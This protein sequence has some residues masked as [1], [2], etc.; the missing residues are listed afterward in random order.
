MNLRVIVLGVLILAI[1]VLFFLYP[2]V[3]TPP[4]H[5]SDHSKL[6]RVAPGNYSYF[7]ATLSPQQTLTVSISSSPQAVDFFVM[8]SSEFATWNSRGNPPADV[9]PQY[10]KLNATNY[11]FTTSTASKAENLTLVFL[12]RSLSAPN[13][14]LVHLVIDTQTTFLQ[15]NEVP[16]LILV[17]G[18]ALILFGATRKDK[19]VVEPAEEAPSQ[20][21][22]GGLAG[23]LGGSFGGR[24][25][26]YCGASVE[27]GAAFCP[28]CKR[29]Q[30]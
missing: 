17:C 23:L 10:S 9:Y 20:P 25:C 4:V 12:S 27:E 30:P 3:M 19:V 15:A 2:T 28:S 22:G 11:S 29:S 18:I 6:V 5:A 13:N 8:N 7:Q 21:S 16:I 1:G 24:T 26:R 14:V